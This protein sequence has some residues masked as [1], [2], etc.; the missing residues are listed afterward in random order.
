[1]NKNASIK[2]WYCSTYTDDSLGSKVRDIPFNRLLEGLREGKDVYTL[3]GVLD[4]CIR[5]RILHQLSKSSGV[6]LDDIYKLVYAADQ[7]AV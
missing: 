3:I 6:S 4:S 1:M 5:V 7:Q 2:K